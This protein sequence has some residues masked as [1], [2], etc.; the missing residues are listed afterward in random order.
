MTTIPISTD[1]CECRYPHVEDIP[2][3]TC[4]RCGL[5]KPGGACGHKPKKREEIVPVI[6]S[7]FY[8]PIVEEGMHET[9][10]IVF[11]VEG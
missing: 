8:T 10:P 4:E 5:N 9:E 3:G 1:D 11:D 7:R 2:E 6:G